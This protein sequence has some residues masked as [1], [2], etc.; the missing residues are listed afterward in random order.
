M[1][2]YLFQPVVGLRIIKTHWERVS[3]ESEP[4]IRPHPPP[5]MITEPLCWSV[6]SVLSTLSEDG[7]KVQTKHENKLGVVVSC[8]S[9][10]N[11]RVNLDSLTKISTLNKWDVRTEISKE[12]SPVHLTHGQTVRVSKWRPRLISETKPEAP[13]ETTFNF[14]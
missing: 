3:G 9:N 14:L 12:I 11:E 8:S 10:K 2:L 5:D 4:V 1:C 7:E 6:T 13:P